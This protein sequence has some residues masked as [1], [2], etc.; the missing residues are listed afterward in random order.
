MSR[1]TIG[2]SVLYAVMVL[3]Y[4]E[5]AGGNSEIHF[6]TPADCFEGSKSRL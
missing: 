4:T 5:D 3:T 6:F 1:L 2:S